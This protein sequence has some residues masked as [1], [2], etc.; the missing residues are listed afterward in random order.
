MRNPNIE[1][2]CFTVAIIV[3]FVCA[4]IGIARGIKPASAV[5]IL[6][7]P[8][9]YLFCL[10]LCYGEFPEWAEPL[11]VKLILGIIVSVVSGVIIR[12]I[13]KK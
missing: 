12:A 10:P 1:G 13:R 2:L 3:C 6:L 7:L 8:F 11:S 4:A 5:I 9:V